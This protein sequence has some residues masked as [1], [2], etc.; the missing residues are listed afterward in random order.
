MGLTS[1]AL[2]LALGIVLEFQG[3]TELLNRTVLISFFG[4]RIVRFLKQLTLF[5]SL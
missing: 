1:V 5:V 4:S 2:S 3:R